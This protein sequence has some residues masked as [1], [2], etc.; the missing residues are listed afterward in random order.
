MAWPSVSTFTG[1]L[2]YLRFLFMNTFSMDSLKK[3]ALTGAVLICLFL[4]GYDPVNADDG[5]I[6]GIAP[7][8]K[9]LDPY[10]LA[11]PKNLL[12]DYPSRSAEGKVNVV[13]EIPAGRTEKWEVRKP[14]GALAWNFKKR[15]PR[16]LKYIGYPGN[17][18]MIPRTL[19]SREMGG[20]GDP[21]DVIA[22]GP[23]V[24]RG[25]V[26]E[27]KLIGVLKLSDREE[28]DDKLIAV[29]ANSPLYK[30]DSIKELDEKFPGISQILEIWFIGYKGSD[31]MQSKGFGGPEE[32]L[33]VLEEA[34]E[35]FEYHQ[36]HW[37]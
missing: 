8:L 18:G 5:I 22:L 1:E 28:R 24:L 15:K 32:A 17:Y 9:F 34:S 21:L 4:V 14:D 6:Y 35:F 29:L 31:K 3:H 13:V 26:V 19:L 36:T 37:Q 27:A 11:G 16:V 10:T 12:N 33:T 25:S 7:D 20:D 30:A 23:P 2:D